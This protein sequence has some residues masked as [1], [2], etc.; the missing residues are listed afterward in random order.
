MNLRDRQRAFAAALVG[1]FV[2]AGV[3]PRG[4]AV[5]AHNYRSQL[6]AALRETYEKT[7]LWLGETAFD[8]LAAAYVDS[9]PPVSWTLDA[10]GEAFIAHLDDAYPADVEVAEIA[11]LDWHLRRAFSGPD[12]RAIGVGELDA[13][14][15]DRVEFD[16]VPT[17]RYCRVRSNAAAIW[18]ALGDGQPPPV[19]QGV[20]AGVGL[21]V[22]REGLS[23]RFASMTADETACLDLALAGASFGE[24]CTWLGQ[25]YDAEQAA[26]I[27]GGC[28][29]AWT[30]EG[31]VRALR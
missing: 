22:W 12:A 9:H 5:Y 4:M 3:D 19:P 11:W 23:P 31:M 6:V 16:F 25:R 29:G 27:A 8:A 26:R 21:R 15:W 14:D 18:R 24:V 30:A 20:E 13:D 7:L 28:L 1:G 17:L 10:Y 2:P